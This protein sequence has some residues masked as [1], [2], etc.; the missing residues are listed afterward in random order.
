MIQTSKI[1]ENESDLIERAKLNAEAF[2]P[3]YD[4][5]YKTIFLFIL[6]RVGEKE[7]CAD[8]TSQVFLKALQNI[9]RYQYKGLPFSAWLYRIAINEINDFFRSQNKQRYVAIEESQLNALHS[10]LTEEFS[11]EHLQI[12]LEE[13]L[14]RLEPDE[15]HLIELRFF[16]GRPFKEVADILNISEVYAKVKTYRTLEKLKKYFIGRT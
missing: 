9:K 13:L 11:V 5:Y 8:L 6:H 2:R 4:H 15:L 14:Q 10:E 7:L 12:R 1:L 16:E 3:L